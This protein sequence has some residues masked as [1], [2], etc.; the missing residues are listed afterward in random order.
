MARALELPNYIG[1]LIRRA[2]QVHTALWAQ[3]VS[4]EI[5]SQKFAVLNALSR[6]PGV[7][8]RTL[9]RLTSLDRSTVNLMI[10][11]LTEQAL[12]SQVRDEEDR[13]RTL[14]SLTDDG[15]ALLDSL[16][17]PAERINELLLRSLPE[18]ERA[19]AVDILSRLA[20]LDEGSLQGGARA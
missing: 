2:E 19:I 11:R 3:H 5:T 4:R 18:G 16:I 17:A 8:Q 14:L 20:S 9:G 10:R 1:H 15:A 6:E 13:R 12:V 7:D